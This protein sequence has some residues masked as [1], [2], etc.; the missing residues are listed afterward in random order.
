MDTTNPT[1]HHCCPDLAQKSNAAGSGSWSLAQLHRTLAQLSDRPP[2]GLWLDARSVLSAGR[3]AALRDM[4]S[5]QQWSL[6]AI[7]S[8]SYLETL[9]ASPGEVALFLGQLL[10][11]I[12]GKLL[13]LELSGLLVAT[14]HAN[15]NTSAARYFEVIARTLESDPCAILTA[16]LSH[17]H[18]LDPEH[19][20]P[21]LAVAVC[22]LLSDHPSP[23]LPNVIEKLIHAPASTWTPTLQP[24]QLRRSEQLAALGE[25]MSVSAGLKGAQLNQ[26]GNEIDSL[27][28]L[29]WVECVPTTPEMELVL[30]AGTKISTKLSQINRPQD[31]EAVLRIVTQLWRWHSSQNSQIVSNSQ[32]V[33]PQLPKPQ[34]PEPVPDPG[35]K[36]GS[37]KPRDLIP[38]LAP[39]EFAHSC[40]PAGPELGCLGHLLESELAGEPCPTQAFVS[41]VPRAGFTTRT[42]ER[43]RKPWVSARPDL[44]VRSSR[45]GR[46]TRRPTPIPR[47][48][49]LAEL[50][51]SE[52]SDPA[53]HCHDSA[54]VHCAGQPSQPHCH[55]WVEETSAGTEQLVEKKLDTADKPRSGAQDSETSELSAQMMQTPTGQFAASVGEE[56]HVSCVQSEV[57]LEQSG[58]CL[59]YTSDAADEEDSVDLGGCRIIKKKKKGRKKIECGLAL[60]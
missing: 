7:G 47:P 34:P 43:A 22:G 11:D 44:R 3:V 48:P 60:G 54:P 56:P 35:Q 46:T 57:Q 21:G 28:V 45:A 30:A 17:W 41:G 16:F 13:P 2:R 26:I 12:P 15:H 38:G 40:E 18:A 50:L 29:G 8:W 52:L 37:D 25:L 53:E 9:D 36:P 6:E 42:R 58:D 10:R 39:D 5:Q 1:P 23:V 31:A 59:L 55:F 33:N 24:D 4:W 32:I 49:T 51:E 19:A 14:Y 27:V 20:S